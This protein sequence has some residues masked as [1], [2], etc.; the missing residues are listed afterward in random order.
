MAVKVLF[1]IHHLTLSDLEV[2]QTPLFCLTNHL[3]T[4]NHILDGDILQIVGIKAA[5]SF[6]NNILGFAITTIEKDDPNYS[7]VTNNVF[8]ITTYSIQTFLS[9]LWFVKDNSI[10][11]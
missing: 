2:A 11:T 7:A 6:A 4:K 1:S 9:F 10:S 8:K 3:P 5:H